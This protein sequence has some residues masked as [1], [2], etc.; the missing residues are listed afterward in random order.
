MLLDF[1]A[2]PQPLSRPLIRTFCTA[3]VPPPAG[4]GN[5]LFAGALLAF[6]ASANVVRGVV[7]LRGHLKRRGEFEATLPENAVRARIS[8]ASPLWG[9]DV[10]S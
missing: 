9:R 4:L 6:S 1:S 5:D 10:V 2:P 7:Q 8:A 3:R